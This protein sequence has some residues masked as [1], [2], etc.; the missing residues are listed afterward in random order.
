MKKA[1]ID[2]EST[3][4]WVIGF[5]PDTNPIVPITKAMGLRVCDVM[6]TEFPVEMPMFWVDCGDDC[7]RDNSYYDE[8]SKTVMLLPPIPPFP[9]LA[10][11]EI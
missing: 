3:V 4:T 5:V 7:T 11:V 9:D 6:D 2:S 1:L 10:P 8:A